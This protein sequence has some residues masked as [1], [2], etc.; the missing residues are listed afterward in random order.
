LRNTPI[1]R[2]EASDAFGWIGQ[3]GSSPK[4]AQRLGDGYA[5]V[6]AVA[7]PLKVS[8]FGHVHS[9]CIATF[10]LAVRQLVAAGRNRV[11]S[12]ALYNILKHL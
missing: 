11:E 10:E 4:G 6:E 3:P 12:D 1:R 2:M 5:A 8:G 9:L 7:A